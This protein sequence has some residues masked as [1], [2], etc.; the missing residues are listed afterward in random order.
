MLYL[1]AT[2]KVIVALGL[3]PNSLGPP[4]EATAPFGSWIVNLIPIGRRHA[5]LFVSCRTL[6]SFP[7]MIGK[8]IPDLQDLPSFL[9]HG[10]VQLGQSLKFSE[11]NAGRLTSGLDRIALCVNEDKSLLGIIRALAA[12]YEHRTKPG[13]ELPGGRLGSI[14]VAVNST[15]R[16]KLGYKTSVEMAL[17]VL[18]ASAA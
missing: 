6:L 1:Q 15:P 7:I 9:N 13:D 18:D 12:D 8:K 4:G 10:L 16:A 14:I 5:Y 11:H 3:D 2:K 17:E